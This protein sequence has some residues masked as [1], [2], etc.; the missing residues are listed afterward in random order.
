MRNEPNE[1]E[2]WA[3]CDEKWAEKYDKCIQKQAK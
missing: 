1:N 2:K 3:K